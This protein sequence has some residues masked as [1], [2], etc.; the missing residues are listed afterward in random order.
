MKNSDAREE[1]SFGKMLEIMEINAKE[2]E[3]F[4]VGE[5]SRERKTFVCHHA[6]CC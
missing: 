1:F 5:K 3:D 2:E 4:A 6:T